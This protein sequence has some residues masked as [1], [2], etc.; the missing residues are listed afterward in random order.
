MGLI[1]F[2]INF[3]LGSAEGVLGEILKGEYSDIT[4]MWYVDVGTQIILAMFFEIGAP[5]YVP[6]AKFV[7]RWC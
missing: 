6:V 3:S 4:S 2:I 1:I 5:H 7:W